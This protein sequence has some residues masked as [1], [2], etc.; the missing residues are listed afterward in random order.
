[1]GIGED[2]VVLNFSFGLSILFHTHVSQSFIHNYAG[3]F[4]YICG[5]IIRNFS[6]LV[7]V[8]SN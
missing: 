7:A 6:F 3:L 8:N 5:E 4:T 1:M 2:I